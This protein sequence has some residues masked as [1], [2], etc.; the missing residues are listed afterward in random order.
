MITFISATETYTDC[1]ASSDLI[2]FST[3]LNYEINKNNLTS[4]KPLEANL[5]INFT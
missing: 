2:M 1:M 3:L 5:S 4:P